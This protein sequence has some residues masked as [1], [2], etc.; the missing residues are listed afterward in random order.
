MT[1]ALQFKNILMIKQ[2]V[3]IIQKP[4][5]RKPLVAKQQN[6]KKQKSNN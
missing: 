6:T 2:W 1:Q 5:R 3:E 4:A